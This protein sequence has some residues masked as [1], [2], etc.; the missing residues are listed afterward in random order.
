[1]DDITFEELIA[2]I[3]DENLQAW[4]AKA[5]FPEDFTLNE[6]FVKT[7][8]AAS[9]AATARNETLEAGK[10]I[11]GYPP[12]VNGAIARASGNKLFFSRT[13]T[14]VSRVVINLDNATPTV[15]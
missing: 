4:W 9:I 2:A 13:S 8:E 10:K 1:M 14:V 6:F 5:N 12:A 3:E 11:L 7:L 15:G